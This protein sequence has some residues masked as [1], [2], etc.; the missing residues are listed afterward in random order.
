MESFF[1]EVYAVVERVPY[2]KVVSYGQIAKI[3]DRPGSAR[4]VGFAMKYCPEGLAWYR[5]VKADGSPAS[6]VPAEL[7]RD[8]LREEGVI[9]TL[10]GRVDME[11]CRWNAEEYYEK[12]FQ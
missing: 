8:L 7:C 2:G 4:A 9:F 5:V 1:K 12:L 10:D 11:A 3:L 6:G